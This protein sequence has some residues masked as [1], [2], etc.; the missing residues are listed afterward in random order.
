MRKLTENDLMDSLSQEQV[1]KQI[2]KRLA[3]RTKDVRRLLL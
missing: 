2:S 1:L 3:E